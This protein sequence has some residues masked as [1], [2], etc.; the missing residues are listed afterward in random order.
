M[1]RKEEPNQQQ[2]LNAA[3][4]AYKA[5]AAEGNRQEEARWANTI[6][7]ILKNRGEYVEALRWLRVDYD[8]S[9]RYLPDKQLLATCQSLGE[10]HLRLQQY[11]DA[12]KYQTSLVELKAFPEREKK[13]LDLAKH[14]NDLIEQQRAMTQL[15]R[16]Y[17]EMFLNS[18]DD[19]TAVRNA[20]KYFISAMKL[21][22]T[23]KLDPLMRGSFLKEYVDA[24]N[25]IGMLELDLDN[26]EEAE[27]ILLKGLNICDDEEFSEDIDTRSRL[28]HNLGNV[29]ME[30]RKWV[31]AKKHIEKDII[32]CK[33]IMHR[34][35]EAKGYVNLGEL[36]YRTQR[37]EEAISSYQKALELAKSLEDEHALANQIRQNIRTVREAMEVMTEIK[38]EEQ[39]LKKL[40]RI[41]ETARGTENERKCLMKQ[42]AS[43]DCLVDKA[44]MIL[45]WIKFR[46]FG[47][48][49]K[50]LASEL[51]DKEKLGDSF[52]IVGE[53]YQKLRQFRKALKW[54]Q[55]GWETF[56]SIGNLEGQA[57][58]KINIG[59]VLDSDGDWAGAL[60]AYQKGIA[61]D[62]NLYSSQISALENIHYSY[63]IRFDNV[64]EA[65]R[66]KLLIDKLKQSKNGGFEPEGSRDCCSETQLDNPSTDDRSDGGFS[67]ESGRLSPL[68]AKSSDLDELLDD[69]MP[70]VSLLQSNRI[71]GKQKTI[72]G[73][74]TNAITRPSESS[75]GSLSTSAGSLNRKRMRVILSDDEDEKEDSC[76]ERLVCEHPVEGIATSDE[77]TRKFPN[78]PANE[79]QDVSP[80]A[81]RCTVGSPL[82]NLENSACSYKSRSSK[83]G[84]QDSRH[85][86]VNGTCEA[87]VN[88]KDH[89]MDNSVHMDSSNFC[90]NRISSS[91]LQACCDKPCQHII[92]RIDNESVHMDLD[93][94]CTGRKLD[95]EKLK[96]E[97][98]C[99]YY[100]KLPREKR[101]RG[102]Y[103]SIATDNDDSV[104]PG[105]VPVIQHMKYG[106]VV[107]ES[108]ETLLSIRE[109]AQG[110]NWIEVSVG[111]M[112]AKHLLKLYI[113][114]CEE[115]SESPNLDVVQKLYNLEVS[116]DE[117]MVSDCQLRDVSVAPLLNALQ[118]HKT[119]AVL[120]L[121]HNLLGNATM[122]KLKQVFISSGQNYGGL[123]L[124][125]HCNQ[126]GPAALFQICEC[127]L[128]YARLEVLNIS[129]NNLSDKCASYLST[130]LRN[131]KGKTLVTQLDIPLLLNA[132]VEISTSSLC[133]HREIPCFAALYSLDIGNCSIT[134]RTIQMVADSLD[135]E[136]V[137][138]HLSIGHN[139]SVSGNALVNLLTKLATLKRFQELNLTGI[140][141]SK[142]VVDSLCRL[143]SNC[144]LSGLLL[145]NSS[146]GTKGAVQLIK[147]LSKDTQDL[148]RLDL[149]FCGLTGNCITTL[150]DEASLVSGILELNL[151]G[152]PMMK[153]CAFAV[154][155][156]GCSQL[157]SIL[158]TPQCSF[159]VL[160]LC[161]CQL[162]L[163]GLIHILQA[164]SEN[165][166]LEELD[167]AD[168]VGVN[169]IQALTDIDENQLEIADSEDELVD[170]E[171]TL[172]TWKNNPIHTTPEKS[173]AFSECEPIQKLSDC[174]KMAG[175]LRLL[176]LSDNGFPQEIVELLFSAWCTGAR[177]CVGRRHVDEKVVHFSV[178]GK[179]CC[180]VRYCC[181]KI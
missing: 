25:N 9:I 91:H 142:P 154:H 15:G 120:D 123:V 20:M 153:E 69:D 156:K 65:R 66:T 75:K 121:S 167:L 3:K 147:P 32:I 87:F 169:E 18:D 33:R 8:V 79:D 133:P 43:L 108:M 13:H 70:L 53:S 144:C 104:S 76:C 99:L 35:G 129:G 170:S 96:V 16:T 171:A 81:S 162:S 71:M 141:V 137:L 126:L 23:I 2:Q 146:I 135:S 134:S 105:L 51:C 31:N 40:E 97:L 60:D 34:Q 132:V 165:H 128:L 102:K 139:Q 164:L 19:H 46:E 78:C 49:K 90:Q 113:N 56:K 150:R 179:N 11:N 151:G 62:G 12:L 112:V 106:E 82:A 159:R 115:L 149:S 47:K 1:G 72:S 157:V 181:R 48:K 119:V 28:H 107:L 55:K 92:F 83:L 168:N 27:R 44:R 39:N 98:A 74:A 131:C 36:N 94:Y 178:E 101:S 88:S 95:L 176:N 4:R 118:M 89:G 37:Y 67:Q 180:G 110:E 61:I 30:M 64:E 122:D 125:L 148:V 130:V 86:R 136:S 54:F 103:A 73:F 77:F 155:L 143:A 24:H 160:V 45:L 84:L 59:N 173:V 158:S 7:N 177:F 14:E 93:L 138:E 80:V 17:H 117:I 152:N 174:I 26:L 116:E 111:V 166:S 127:P 6:G 21:A 85:F 145:G 161:K 5:A 114:C 58:A 63:M 22:E 42:N 41:T 57:L 172:S 52:L 124:D 38:K 140:K 163:D 100:L 175:K 68:V 50:R 29:Y 10:V 109:H